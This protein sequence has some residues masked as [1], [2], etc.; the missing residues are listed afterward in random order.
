MSEAGRALAMLAQA[1]VVLQ[2]CEH[3]LE[4][5]RTRLVGADILRGVLISTLR[6]RLG[7]LG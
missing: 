4:I 2:V 6:Y 3:V 1:E 5:P 7:K